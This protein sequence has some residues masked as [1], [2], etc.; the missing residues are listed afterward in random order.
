MPI[1]LNRR[2]IDQDLSSYLVEGDYEHGFRFLGK[3]PYQKDGQRWALEHIEERNAITREVCARLGVRMID[4]A[5]ALATEN[6][7]DFRENFLD[8]VHIRPRAFRMVAAIIH[9]EIKDL[10]S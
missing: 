8:V 3:L 1:A 2:I 4:L 7:T 6:L 5:A 10:L 9:N